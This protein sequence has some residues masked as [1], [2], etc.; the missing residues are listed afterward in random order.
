MSRTRLLVFAVSALALFTAH[1]CSY[2][3]ATARAMQCRSETAWTEPVGP[4]VLDLW[5]A[6]CGDADGIERAMVSP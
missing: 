2:P 4:R 5:E 3:Q 1:H 6:H